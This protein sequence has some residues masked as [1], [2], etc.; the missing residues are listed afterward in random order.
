M[1]T[2]WAKEGKAIDDV[3]GK[4]AEGKEPHNDGQRLGSMDLLLQRRPSPLPRQRMAL[5]LF[6]LSPSRQ[7]N[8]QVD[9]QHEQKG[10]QDTSKEVVVHHVV[11]GDHILKE[12]GHLALPTAL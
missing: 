1:G 10:H 6:Q 9:A 3:Q 12:T 8:P 2:L 11:H 5:H 4:P 7:E